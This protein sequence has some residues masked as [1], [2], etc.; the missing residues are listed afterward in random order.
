M[1]PDPKPS[2]RWLPFVGGAAVGGSSP[3]LLSVR[4]CLNSAMKINH[5]SE[6]PG[7]APDPVPLP[8]DLGLFPSPKP[9][10]LNPL[11]PNLPT[12]PLTPQLLASMFAATCF[13]LLGMWSIGSAQ[14]TPSPLP[15]QQPPVAISPV[16]PAGAPAGSGISA[17]II[18]PSTTIRLAPKFR[19]AGRGLP[20]MP[21][22]PPLTSPVGA[23]DSRP[24][25]VG[26]L[27]CDP[28]VDFPC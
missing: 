22:G 7:P 28:V 21:G 13:S 2:W 15:T 9:P 20:G 17:R 1:L 25:T 24:P 18:T 3:L 6:R 16:P 8:P 23:R 12:G 4:V 19:S 11:P 5:K 26:P 14:L 27:F 10:L